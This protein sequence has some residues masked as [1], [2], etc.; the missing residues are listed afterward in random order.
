VYWKDKEAYSI[1]SIMNKMPASV[2][3]KCANNVTLTTRLA[4]KAS[5]G[6][7]MPEQGKPIED[8]PFAKVR[9]LMYR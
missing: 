2:L 5:L 6:E 3:L 7:A 9:Y 4:A 1:F 8:R